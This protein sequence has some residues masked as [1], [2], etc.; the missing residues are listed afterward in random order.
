MSKNQ[1]KANAIFF[2]PYA[3]E[4]ARLMRLVDWS[5]KI[6]HEPSPLENVAALIELTYGQKRGIIYLSDVFHKYSREDQRRY[7]V[8][9]LVH[10]HIE[11][12]VMPM[13]SLI[14]K[15]A[16]AVWTCAFEYSTDSLADVIAPL[17]PLPPKRQK[18]RLAASNTV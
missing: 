8:H 9:E 18:T 7:L 11:P 5:L 1:I 12:T 16:W 13:K 2:V 14:K 3:S 17:M 10:C 15:D 4:L 6:A